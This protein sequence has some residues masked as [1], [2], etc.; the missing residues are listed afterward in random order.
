M[1]TPRNQERP[2]EPMSNG[3]GKR[4]IRR[5]EQ[6]IVVAGFDGSDGAYRALDASALMVAGRAGSV[7]VVFVAHVPPVGD[8]ASGAMPESLSCAFDN[9]ELVFFDAVRSRLANVEL[10]WRFQRRDGPIAHELMAAADEQSRL[11][12]EDSQVVIVVGSAAHAVHR[13][14]GSVPGALIRN[15]RYPVLVVP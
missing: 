1:L 12:G 10:R 2:I 5:S 8:L 6:L 9:D 3:L 14:V 13:F 4:K 7:E 11:C 15:R